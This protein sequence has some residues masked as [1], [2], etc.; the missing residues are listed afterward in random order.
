M[1]R[2]ERV[3]ASVPQ[4]GLRRATASPLTSLY[5]IRR[6]DRT[7]CDWDIEAHQRQLSFIAL[8]AIDDFIHLDL[9]SGQI[10]TMTSSWKVGLFSLGFSSMIFGTMLA[11]LRLPAGKF[12]LITIPCCALLNTLIFAVTTYVECSEAWQTISSPDTSIAPPQRQRRRRDSG[13]A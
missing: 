4:V 7:T 12:F 3:P 2:E 11:A 5:K 1:R 9:H 10:A 8:E 6:P 13:R